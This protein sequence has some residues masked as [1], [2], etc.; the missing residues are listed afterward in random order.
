MPRKQIGAPRSYVVDGGTYPEGPFRPE[1]PDSVLAAALFSFNL[2]AW[3]QGALS[4]FGSEPS[5]IQQ[6]KNVAQFEKKFG[7][8][9]AV[10]S[11]IMTGSGYGDMGTVAKIEAMTRADLWGNYSERIQLLDGEYDPSRREPNF[12]KSSR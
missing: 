6:E 7:I 10:M 4:S 3:M 8:T 12:M 5:W 11:R 9:H 1:T 2:K